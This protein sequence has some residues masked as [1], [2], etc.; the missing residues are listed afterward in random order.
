M[1]GRG[2]TDRKARGKAKTPP[3][4]AG[5]QFPVGRVHRLVRKCNYPEG[6]GAGAPVYMPAML[7]YLT[8]E[9]LELAGN[10]AHDNKKSR[11]YTPEG[12]LFSLSTLE[13]Q[14]IK[15]YVDSAWG[16]GWTDKSYI[17]RAVFISSRDKHNKR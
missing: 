12:R 15:D 8:P 16:G 14:A 10:A 9:I 17:S 1:S 11:A 7:E 4:L 3:S 2:K 13:M 6:V 5:L